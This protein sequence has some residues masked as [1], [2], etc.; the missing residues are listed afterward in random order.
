[1]LPNKKNTFTGVYS[2]PSLSAQCEYAASV[3]CNYSEI[4]FWHLFRFVFL[5]LRLR[6]WLTQSS[7]GGGAGAG[8]GGAG[9]AGSSY[10]LFDTASFL[11]RGVAVK[12][13]HT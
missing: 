9:E 6:G 2:R 13:S 11:G 8:V 7:H 10:A 1:M 3:N 4:S 12:K 5:L